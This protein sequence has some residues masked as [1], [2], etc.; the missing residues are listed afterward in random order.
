MRPK[1]CLNMIVKNESRIIRRCLESLRPAI[2]CWVIVDTGSTDGTQ[3]LIRQYLAGI[4]GELHERPW[5]NFGRNRTEAI[6]LAEGKAD[7]LL[8]CDADMA[9]KI[10]DPAWKGSLTAES[11]LVRQDAGTFSYFNVRLIN[12]RSSGR[13]AYWGAT[14][15]FLGGERPSVEIAH[16]TTEA[17]AFDDFGDGGSKREKFE[18]DARLLQEELDAIERLERRAA[19]APRDADLAVEV[20]GARHLQRRDV[21]Y[22]AQTWRDMGELQK[23]LEAYQRR[24]AMGGWDEEVW[25]AL[26][27]VAKLSERLGLPAPQVTERYLAAYQ[28]RPRR[29]EPLVELARFHRERNELALA[30]LFALRAINVPKPDDTLFLDTAA[31]SWRALDEFA[32]ASYW[33]GEY[34]AAARAC[35]WLLENGVLPFEQLARVTDNL[36]FS[37][38]GMAK[39]MGQQE[40]QPGEPPSPGVLRDGGAATPSVTL[41]LGGF[42]PAWN[43]AGGSDTVAKPDGTK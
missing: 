38:A 33:M 7:Y 41:S 13:W 27:E 34:K 11:Y 16:A 19:T 8:L 29:A 26:F 15:E 30:H 31:Y 17:I 42:V 24:A 37:R 39:A 12:A 36:N 5:V 43:W 10:V 25:Y 28:N 9:L 22:L 14:H 2:D 1:V 6:R 23:S 32:V 18:R 20:E 4:P 40:G 21:F 35:E 3:D